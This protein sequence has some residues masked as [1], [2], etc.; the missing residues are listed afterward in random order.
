MKMVSNFPLFL[1]SVNK[2]YTDFANVLTNENVRLQETRKAL[3]YTIEKGYFSKIIIVDGSNQKVLSNHEIIQLATKGIEVEQLLFQQDTKLVKQFGKGNG[4]MQITNYMVKNSKLANAAGGFVK[5]TPRYYFDNIDLIMPQ[6][7][8]KS[9][10]FFFY[11]PY[12]VKSIKPFV[13]TIFYKTTIEF[14]KTH[15]ENS[16]CE[17]STEIKGYAESVFYRNIVNLDKSS[18]YVEF[19]HFSG[20]AGTTGKQI[21]NQYFQFRNICSKLGLMCYDFK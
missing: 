15:F 16:I 11:Y 19:P 9:N 17:H 7:N 14:Y 8:N 12:I 2:T 6:I 21:L 4:E 5:L 18:V 20:L 13:C 10:I 1:P 3:F